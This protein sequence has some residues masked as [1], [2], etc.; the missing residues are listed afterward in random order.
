[1]KLLLGQRNLRVLLTLLVRLVCNCA[2]VSSLIFGSFCILLWS[3]LRNFRAFCTSVYLKLCQCSRFIK[4][5]C[6]Y[7]FKQKP[8]KVS[9]F[10]LYFII[11]GVEDKWM[12]RS[13]AETNNW[14]W[15][16]YNARRGKRFINWSFWTLKLSNKFKG[17]VIIYRGGRGGVGVEDLGL[18]KVKFSRSPLWML[19]HRSYPP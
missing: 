17:P 4:P 14:N 7:L 11:K 15:K 18:S 2:V 12:I 16:R 13:T 10:S 3:Q 5:N 9:T 6:V 1:M 19:I 8:V